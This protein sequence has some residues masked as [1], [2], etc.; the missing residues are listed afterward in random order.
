MYVKNIYRELTSSLKSN[1]YTHCVAYS[2][3]TGF[4]GYTGNYRFAC[5][6]DSSTCS[7]AW[8]ASH[9]KYGHPFYLLSFLL[10]LLFADRA[11]THALISTIIIYILFAISYWGSIISVLYL[12][13]IYCFYYRALTSSLI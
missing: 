3:G 1:S 5:Q 12:H 6:V 4:H 11:L 9:T 10:Y 7:P 2:L 13:L 8:D